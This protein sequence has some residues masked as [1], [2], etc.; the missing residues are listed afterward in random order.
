M[1]SAATSETAP[2]SSWF[3]WMALAAL[4]VLVGA[5]VGSTLSSVQYYPSADDGIYRA[6]MQNIAAHGPVGVPKLLT[7]AT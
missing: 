1:N 7:S 3:S 5:L 4:V 2:T 6:Y